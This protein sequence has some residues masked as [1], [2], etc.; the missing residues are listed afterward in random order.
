MLQEAEVAIV[1][2][3][4]MGGSLAAAL[5]TRQACRAVVGVARRAEIA[6]AALKRKLVHRATTDLAEG[7]RQADMVILATPVRVILELLPRVGELMKAG[8]L[9]MDVGSTKTA[10]VEAMSTLPERV[11]V[12]GAHPMCGKESSGLAAADVDLFRG[13]V[14]VLSPL[15]RTLSVAMELAQ[16]LV[17][18]LCARPMVM[19]AGRHDR[20]A[21]SVSHLPY[22]VSCALM[23]T[24]QRLA[25]GDDSLWTIA[26]G[27]FRDTT[28][29]A[30]SDLTMMTDI[31]ATNR[32]AVLETLRAF[33]AQLHHL[34]RELES[35][36]ETALRSTLASVGEQR[37]SMFG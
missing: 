16:E 27:G 19:E 29:L 15:A 3:G 32:Q 7:V 24:A 35:E 18:A 2:L 9:V 33:E 25:Q 1:G 5:T 14:F 17:A 4:L 8:A 31:L 12:L 23:A 28:R 10:I 26:A 13:C 30:A 21:A 22:L 11:Q 37:R 6:E 36:D 20:L 34:S